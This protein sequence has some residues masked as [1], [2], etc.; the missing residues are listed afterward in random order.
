MGP[1][2][3]DKKNKDW[4]GNSQDPRQ[5]LSSGA[6]FAPWDRFLVSQLGRCN[7]DLFGDKPGML[8]TTL[9]YTE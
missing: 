8:L 7:W 4:K 6:K 5:W 1:E 2:R 3:G 9:D